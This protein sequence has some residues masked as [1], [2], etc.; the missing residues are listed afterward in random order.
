MRLKN[1]LHLSILYPDM[2]A[3]IRHQLVGEL[4]EMLGYDNPMELL[5]SLADMLYRLNAYDWHEESIVSYCN[6][7]I[8]CYY[9]VVGEQATIHCLTKES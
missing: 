6:A 8:G 4:Q 7:V 3:S 2:S 9:K 5:S 1:L